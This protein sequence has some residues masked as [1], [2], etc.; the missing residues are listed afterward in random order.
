M[1]LMIMMTVHLANLHF[2]I[3]PIIIVDHVTQIVVFVKAMTQM[4]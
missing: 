3:M 4:I 2:N 1:Q